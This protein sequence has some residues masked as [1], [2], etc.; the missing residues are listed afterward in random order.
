MTNLSETTLLAFV[1]GELDPAAAEEVSQQ[2]AHDRA[3]AEMVRALRSSAALVRTAFAEPEWQHVPSHLAALVEGRRGWPG[4]RWLAGRR[5]FG[6]ALGASLAACAAGLAAG[7]ALERPW[8][9]QKDPGAELLDEVAEYHTDFAGEAS[10]LAIA[11]A[12]KAAAIETWFAELLKRPVQIPDLGR[13]GLAFQ[14]A[15]LL[16]AGDRLVAQLLYSAAGKEGHPLGVCITAWPGPPVP[17]RTDE[18]DGVALALWARRGFAYVLVGWMRS[19]LL[20]RIAAALQ[21]ALEQA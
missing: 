7:I 10:R 12:S 15:R 20:E 1:D 6:A 3:A 17:L 13:F 2:L 11:P 18:R 9:E 19:P 14:G 5:Q 16:I 8:P 4:S 21:P